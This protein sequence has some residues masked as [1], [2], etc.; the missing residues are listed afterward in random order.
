MNTLPFP[1]GDFY[2]VNKM[3][4]KIKKNS[5]K[6]IKSA[7]SCICWLSKT[8]PENGTESSSGNTPGLHTKTCES[9]DR[10]NGH[11]ETAIYEDNGDTSRHIYKGDAPQT[12]CGSKSLNDEHEKA[13]S[14]SEVRRRFAD[15]LKYDDELDRK[16]EETIE[17]I[18]REGNEASE[19][20][21]Q[22]FNEEHRKLGEEE[23]KVM[24]E[25]EKACS[26]SE[27]RLHKV[28]GTLKEAQEYNSTLDESIT[29][30]QREGKET[31]QG[32]ELNLVSSM[33]K[34]RKAMEELRRTMMTDLKIGWDS[35]KRKLSFTRNL[36]NGAPIPN[37]ITFPKVTCTGISVS[38]DCD[39]RGLSEDDRTKVKYAVEMKKGAEEER[40]WREVYSGV[41]TKCSVSGLDKDTE[42]DVRVKCTIG[43]IQGG[44]SDFGRV[45]TPNIPVPSNIIAMSERLNTITLTW[46]MA[47]GV[48]LYQIEVDGSDALEATTANTFTKEELLPDTEH[49][50]RVR[51]LCEKLIGGWSDG[52]KTRTQKEFEGTWKECPGNIC[53]DK[54]Y[55][56]DEGNPRIAT[57]TDCDKGYCTIVGNAPLPLNKVTSW[58]VKVQKSR[59]DDGGCIFVGVAPSDIDQNEGYNYDKCGWY[60]YCYSSSLC[61]GSIRGDKEYGPRK[62]NGE[63]VRTGDI[64]GVVMDTAKG[65]LSF[66]VDGVNLGV[67]YEGIPLDEPL[68]P[69][70]ILGYGGDSVELVNLTP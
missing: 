49:T 63:Y 8:R 35:E 47:E 66:V 18:R 30:M 57:K 11:T 42:Y 32:M 53:E 27:D 62:G 13:F 20:I 45:R 7:K 60:F 5:P 14:A 40:A 52:V 37:N 38:W 6:P 34:Q 26:E 51:S 1:V 24:M 48:S 19:K 58:S 70:V 59:D 46:N 31:I 41:E 61:S 29:K 69:C 2:F 3:V 10:C 33:E 43:D 15:V 39:T 65:E 21:K 56:V 67:A 44:W 50:F 4:Q 28:L 23:F 64:V 36:F 68:V 9:P 16:I 17:S 55:I 22:T 54:K 12:L 25:L